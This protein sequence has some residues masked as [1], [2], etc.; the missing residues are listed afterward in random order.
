MM[1]LAHWIRSS[2]RI[3]SAPSAGDM[4][5]SFREPAENEQQKRKSN[6]IF[7]IIFLFQEQQAAVI[8]CGANHKKLK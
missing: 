5:L 4:I 7:E 3:F 6:Q 1:R 8:F 2:I